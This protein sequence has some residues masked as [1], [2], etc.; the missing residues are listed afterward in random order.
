MEITINMNS[1]RKFVESEEFHQFL[2][3]HTTDFGTAAWVLQTLL[4]ACSEA[5]EKLAAAN[6]G[7]GGNNDE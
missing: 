6:N 1:I 4:E 3:S 2:L 5:E 7:Q